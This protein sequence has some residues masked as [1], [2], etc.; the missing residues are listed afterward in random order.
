MFWGSI[1]GNVLVEPFRVAD[2]VKMPAKLHIDFI[3]K[4][5]EPWHKKKDS[6]FRKK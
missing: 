6:S 1:I 2:G 4:H 5:H 3:K